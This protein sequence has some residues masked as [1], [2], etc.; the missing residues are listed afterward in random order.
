MSEEQ[1]KPLAAFL[2][3]LPIGLLLIIECFAESL[4]T[5]EKID[6]SFGLWCA[7]CSAT[8]FSCVY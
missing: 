6:S 2:A 7:D 5:A 4:Q 8:L 1:S 3:L